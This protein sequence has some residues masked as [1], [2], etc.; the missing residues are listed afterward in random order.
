LP[1]RP[2]GRRRAAESEESRPPRRPGKKADSPPEAE[3]ASPAKAASTASADEDVT[4][5]PDSGDPILLTPQVLA[6]VRKKAAESTPQWRAF[7]EELD[8]KLEVVV[9]GGY[10]GSGLQLISDYA[11]AYQVLKESDPATASRY[12]DKAIAL[13]KSGLHD[14]QKGNWTA[15][16]FLARG[17]GNTRAFIL[18]DRGILA[19]SVKVYLAK[20]STRKVTRGKSGGPDNVEFYV[21][22]LKVSDTPDGPADYREGTDWRHNPDLANNLIDWP[23]AA[24]QPAPGATYYVTAAVESSSAPAGF[25]RSGNAV[26]LSAAPSTS[27][28][29]FVEYVYN[30]PGLAYQQT[31]AGDGGFNSILIDSGYTSRYLGKHVGMG[32]DWLDGYPGLSPALMRE[33]MDMLVRWADHARDH[34]YRSNHLASNYGTGTYVSWVMTALA[35]ARRH[36]EG[37]RLLRQVLGHR[38]RNLLPL[39]ENPQ[40]SLKGGF[41]AE[42]WNYG[43]LATQNLLLAGLGLEGRG[44]IP[45][46]DAE[47]RWAGEVIRH[48]VTAQAAPG[49]VYDAGDWYAYPA[50]FPGKDLFCVLGALADDRAARA[51]ANFI[52]QNS[53]AAPAHDMTDLLFR[54]PAAPAAF[55]ADLPLQ[56]YAEGTGLLLA[57]SDWGR[58][59][60][61]VSLQMGNLLQADHQYYAPG[62]MEIRRGADELLINGNAP[63][64]NQPPSTKSTHAN[65]VV[66][67]DN[68]DG[69]Q[70][71]RYAMGVWYGKPGVRVT[72]GDAGEDF[73]YLAGDC[74]AAYSPKSQPGGGGPALELTR[75]LAYLPPDYVVVYD[76]V[77][78]R[79]PAYRKQLRWHF[80]RSPEVAGSAFVAAA[81]SS[82]LFGQTFSS[83]PLKTIQDAVKVGRAVVQQVVIENAE[84]AERVRYVTTFQVAPAG[85]AKV[86]AQHVKTE[87]A[88]M[89]GAL[90]GDRLVLFGRDPG[91]PAARPIAYRVTGVGA[92]HHLLVDLPPGQEY[93]VKAAGARQTRVKASPQGTVSFRTT[94][95]RELAVELVPAP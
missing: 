85:T 31:S 55:W 70:V 71:Y 18:P 52:L 28:A 51:Y 8:R 53:P 47:R 20:V 23:A 48:L 69:T 25:T 58:S 30:G 59:P 9:H 57:R 1:P 6:A 62:M 84:P 46:A 88:A 82:K 63:G 87:D 66:V 33:A 50:P 15:R 26:T 5:G 34:G 56:H 49:K 91:P 65:T 60:T 78:T 32:L 67:D 2:A 40:D 36:P 61:W 68:G 86:L 3:R 13:I 81:G 14:L 42:G 44:V 94:V 74:R 16:Q 64:D 35:L 54:D 41:W 90:L 19:S 21:K 93:E 37:P 89:E 11:L 27:Q 24:K 76:R 80:V 83:V 17:D 38:R 95:K 77:A 92:V 45:A 72:A 4:P 39:L 79:K 75:Q 12:A 29:V 73:V 43:S 22:F 7:K 10:Q